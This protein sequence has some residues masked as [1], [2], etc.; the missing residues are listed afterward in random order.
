[1][2]N[3]IVIAKAITQKLENGNNMYLAKCHAAEHLIV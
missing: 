3:S 2:L 1:M